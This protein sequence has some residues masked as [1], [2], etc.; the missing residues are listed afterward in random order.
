MKPLKLIP[1]AL[2]A[3][4]IIGLFPFAEPVQL[5]KIEKGSA[6]LWRALTREQIDVAQELRTCYL[7]RA[8]R[9]DIAALRKAGAA[10]EVIERNV[11]N[12]SYVLLPAVSEDVRAALGRAGRLM[13][14]EP[15]IFLF[16]PETGDLAPSLPPGLAW[17]ALPSTTILPFLRPP[18]RAAEPAL[19]AEAKNDIVSRLAGEVS[20]ANLRSIVQTLQ[21]FK[22]RFTATPGC[23]AAGQFI[24]SY[25]AGLGLEVRFEDV[26][27]TE[28]PTRNV[29]AELPGTVYPDAALIVCGH[30]DSYSDKRLTLA[31]GADDNA[32][33]TAATM[34]A[35]RILSRQ[36]LDFTVRFIAFTAEELGL[37][38]SSVYARDARSHG[39]NI[40]GV[41][42]LDMIAY[43]DRMPEDLTVIA[44]PASD[45]LAAKFAAVSSAYGLIQVN[46][47]VDA[48][49]LFSDHAPF[50]DTGYS[51]VCGIEDEP[52]T[53]PYYH[54]TTDTIDTLNFDFYTQ[55][56]RASL[57]TL[58]ELAQPVRAGYPATPRGLTLIS[59]VY[60]SLFGA[61]VNNELS[62]PASPGASGYNIYRADVS[63]LDYQKL[64]PAPLASPSYVDRELSA[65]ASYFYV[66][67]AIGPTGL[68]SN[69]SIEV[70]A[71]LSAA[72]S[73]SSVAGRLSFAF[74]G[75]R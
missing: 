17:K 49:A 15:G 4:G 24:F 33:G 35:A 9:Q 72:A 48:S 41:L 73:V 42:D 66:V 30:Y 68:E 16:R 21:D 53:N 28:G 27:S 18:G 13:A 59:Y 71:V 58:A 34:E 54:K 2:L 38:G 11:G 60:E 8:D 22:T 5:I 44:D 32:S 7:A 69:N 23:E 26:S 52:I 40:I 46:R 47:I 12:L 14:V 63:H 25:F 43:A 6:G 70:E 31:P 62:W 20:S 61:I 10:V 55:A 36:P 37:V 45:W 51:A 39:E 50:W 65:G 1:L 57:A 67:T 29:V 3:T 19:A 74:G 56:A 64:N 75:A